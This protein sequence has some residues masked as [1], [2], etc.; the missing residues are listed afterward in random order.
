MTR[1]RPWCDRRAR[2]SLL[3]AFAED[4][5]PSD[6]RYGDGSPIE[7]VTLREL[8]DA[9]EAETTS[10]E[11]QNGDVLLLDN[12]LV[13]HGREPYEGPRKVRTAMVDPYERLYG[14]PANRPQPPVERAS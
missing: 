3:A 10:F 14:S 4:E 9:Y 11:W 6:A 5:L 7:D 13:A 8:R 2:R 1:C 12:M